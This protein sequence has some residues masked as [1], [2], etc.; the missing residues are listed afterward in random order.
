MPSTGRPRTR[1]SQWQC[2]PVDSPVLP[3]ETDHLAAPDEIAGLHV[4]PAHVPVERGQPVPVI[5]HNGQSVP[6]A[7]LGEEDQS[8][9]GRAHRVTHVPVDVDAVVLLDLVVDGM[10]ARSVARHDLAVLDRVQEDPEGRRRLWLILLP[11]GQ[12]RRDPV[13][14]ADLLGVLQLV[15]AAADLDLLA[16]PLLLDGGGKGRG[17]SVGLA[18]AR[19]LELGVAPGDLVARCGCRSPILLGLVAEVVGLDAQHAHS[20]HNRLAI[21]D[22]GFGV[23]LT[24]GDVFERPGVLQRGDEVGHRCRPAAHVCLDRL[25][26]ESLLLAGQ[27]GLDV[28]ERHLGLVENGSASARARL[29]RPPAPV[30]PRRAGHRDRPPAGPAPRPA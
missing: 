30:A 23:H 9:F 2:G 28:D 11:T 5:D 20:F 6:A 10:K 14:L 13:G 3:D 26:A 8:V 25:V 15:L 1:T 17:L 18:G 4:E 24:L 22:D 16:E 19:L 27:T 12:H 29:R 7:F 21:N